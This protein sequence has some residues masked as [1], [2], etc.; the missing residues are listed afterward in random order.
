[1]AAWNR[2]IRSSGKLINIV[3]HAQGWQVPQLARYASLGRCPNLDVVR[4]IYAAWERGDWSSVEWAHPE[5]EFDV[6]DGPEPGV[7]IGVAAM[8]EPWQKY[9]SA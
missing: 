7:R 3:D 9:L 1:V 2:G 6:V 4:S 5:I 8:A